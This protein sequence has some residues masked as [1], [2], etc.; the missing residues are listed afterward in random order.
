MRYEPTNF[1]SLN[2]NDYFSCIFNDLIKTVFCHEYIT[3]VF[4]YV[5]I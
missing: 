3:L 4:L 5:C 2:W 1:E